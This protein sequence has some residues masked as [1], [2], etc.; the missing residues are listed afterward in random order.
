[1]AGEGPS[2]DIV[3]KVKTEGCVGLDVQKAGRTALQAKGN[4]MCKGS[5]AGRGLD[6]F[7]SCD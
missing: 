2:E 5:E 1:M 7:K 6:Y 3:F 4:S